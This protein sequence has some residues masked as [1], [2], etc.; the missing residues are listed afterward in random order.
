VERRSYLSLLGTTLAG[1]V[2]GCAAG[3]NQSVRG[4]TASSPAFDDEAELPVRFTCDGDGVSPPFVVD[5]VPEPTESLAVIAKAD[6][7]GITKPAFWT[8]W[9]VPAGTERIPAGLPGVASISTLD[10][11]SQGRGPTGEVGYLPPC[12]PVGQSY[13]HWFQIYAVETMLTVGGDVT[14]ETA[15][16]AIEA[17][18]LASTRITV[19]VTRSPEASGSEN[20]ARNLSE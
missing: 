9:N 3:S 18:T 11:A 20:A 2:A 1:G 12:P 16:E 7:G 6:P 15:I 5:S 19:Q 13:S 17:G 4:L 14:H 8:L 10:G